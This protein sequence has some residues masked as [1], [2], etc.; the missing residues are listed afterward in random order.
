MEAVAKLGMES[1]SRTSTWMVSWLWPWEDMLTVGVDRLIRGTVW[2]LLSV[3][4]F[5]SV[6]T[7]SLCAGQVSP[8]LTSGRRRAI[9]GEA[10]LRS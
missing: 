5:L 4:F 7:E 2:S 10:Q 1:I 8:D 6:W 3:V 9:E